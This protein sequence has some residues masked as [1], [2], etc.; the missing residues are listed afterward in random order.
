[1]NKPN[2][3]EC[4]RDIGCYECGIRDIE[5]IKKYAENELKKAI[6]LSN[7]AKSQGKSV[8][9][10]AWNHTRQAYMDMIDKLSR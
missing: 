6:A 3:N 9:A 2:C 1:M 7:E 10:I 5:E 4:S 8:E